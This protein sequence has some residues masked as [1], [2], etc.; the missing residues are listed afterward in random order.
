MTSNT[1]YVKF[2]APVIP[3]S[4]NALMQAVDR[5]ISQ[6][7]RRMTLMISSPGGDVFQGL[8][9]YNYLKG[10]PLEITTHNFGSVDSIGVVLFCAGTR[11]LSVPSARFLLH[12]VMVNFPGPV[13]LEEK[14]LEERLKGLQIDMGSIARII[15]NATSKDPQV[16]LYDLRNRLTLMGQEG[17]DYGLVHEI[18][19]E[20]YEPGAEVISIQMGSPANAQPSHPQQPPQPGFPPGFSYKPPQN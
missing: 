20:L 18:K 4:I 13:S 14:Q 11:R 1:F 9:T 2:F 17:V 19:S 12:G 16:I 5:K 15:S 8:S 7:A 3:D 10:V 6:G